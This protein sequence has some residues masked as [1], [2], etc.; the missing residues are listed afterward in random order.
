MAMFDLSLLTSTILR[1]SP[2]VGC[3]LDSELISFMERQNP[4]SLEEAHLT[5]AWHPGT[6]ETDCNGH[7]MQLYPRKKSQRCVL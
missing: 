3:L 4:L 5:L 7:T 2:R 6:S 1:L